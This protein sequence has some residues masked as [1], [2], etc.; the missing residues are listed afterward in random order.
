VRGLGL[1]EKADYIRS[2]EIIYVL[3]KV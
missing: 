1:H 2:S 3:A